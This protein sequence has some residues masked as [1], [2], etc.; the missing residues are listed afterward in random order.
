[1]E[2]RKVLTIVV[3]TFAAGAAIAS[4]LFLPTPAYARKAEVPV[5]HDPCEIKGVCE[6]NQV[7][8][9]IDFSIDGVNFS[10]IPAYDGSN[11]STCGQRL[12][13]NN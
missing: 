10:G 8:C 11:P 3:F 9:Q 2:L 5:L 1:M 4:E 7:D 13:M 6:G 12:Q